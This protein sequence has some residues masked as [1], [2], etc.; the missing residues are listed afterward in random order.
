M[1]DHSQIVVWIKTPSLYIDNQV[2]QDTTPLKSL[3]TQFI[4][5]ENSSKQFKVA[6][7]FHNC[8]LLTDKFLNVEFPE[9]ESGV[10]LVVKKAQAI[11][12]EAAKHS[13]KRKIVKRRRCLSKIINK[14][15]FNKECKLKR[16][17][18]R[19]LA[20]LKHRDPMNLKIREA[21]IMNSKNTEYF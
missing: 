2:P 8:Q 17:E 7:S 12:I 18:V 4:W 21:L 10:D 15:W 19:K 11:L 9:T 3:P 16:H 20:N 14:K 5:D 1:S 6:F 13:L